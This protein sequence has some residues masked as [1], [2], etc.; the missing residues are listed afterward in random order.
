MSNL[1]TATGVVTAVNGQAG[2]ITLQGGGGTNETASTSPA[3][4]PRS[5]DATEEDETPPAV[6]S[7]MVE[8]EHILVDY[9]ELLNKRGQVAGK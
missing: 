9:L 7:T 8:A 2:A 4:A 5:V 1:V 6:D 3:V